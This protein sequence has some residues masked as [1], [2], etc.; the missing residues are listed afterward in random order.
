MLSSV[1][2]GR[3]EEKIAAFLRKARGDTTYR[4]FARKV[5][6]TPSMLFRFE[7]QQASMT[8]DSLQKITAHLRVSLVDVLGE[9]E[10]RRKGALRDL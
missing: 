7:Q 9:E 6:I 10:V 2:R 1:Q 5:G 4:E 8:L 3:L